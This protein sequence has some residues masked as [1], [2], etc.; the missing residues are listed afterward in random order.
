MK[1][2]EHRRKSTKIDENHRKSLRICENL[3]TSQKIVE[4]IN[5]ILVFTIVG[6]VFLLPF[7]GFQRLLDFSEKAARLP[8]SGQLADAPLRRPRQSRVE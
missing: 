7:N 6:N 5:C 1:T 4:R 3:R 8:S 2:Y